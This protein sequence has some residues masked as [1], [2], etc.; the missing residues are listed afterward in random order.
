MINLAIV[1]IVSI[2][3]DSNLSF[4]ENYPSIFDNHFS[5]SKRLINF[6]IKHA[7]AIIIV[8]M[9]SIVGILMRKS[10]HKHH[11][12]IKIIVLLLYITI[13]IIHEIFDHKLIFVCDY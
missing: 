13:I 1:I 4:K 11:S 8:E 6:S 10:A 9:L 5:F 3:T 2:T 12:S 7:Y